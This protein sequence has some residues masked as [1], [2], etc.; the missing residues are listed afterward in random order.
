[1]TY[2]SNTSLQ[3]MFRDRLATNPDGKALAFFNPDGTYT[4][5]TFREFHE[6]G[7][8]CGSILSEMGMSRGDVCV[9]MLP[10]E[11]IS[12]NVLF[13]SLL[14]GALPLMVAPPVVRGLHSNLKD[15][16]EHVVNTTSA[17][18][19]VL[20][21]DERALGE[22]LQKSHPEIDVLYTSAFEQ[23][24]DA[25]SAPLVYPGPA[26][27]AA[28]Q[29][30]S[31][32]TGF[33]RVCVWDQNAVLQALDGMELA[34]KLGEED[35]CVNWTPPVP[36][37]GTYQQFHALHGKGDTAGNAGDHQF[38][39]KTSDVVAGIVSKRCNGDLVTKFRLY[40]YSA[41]SE[42]PPSQGHRPQQGQGVLERCRTHTP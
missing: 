39:E 13:G 37:Y 31:G 41:E 32:T 24:G 4:W 8:R 25:D 15:V 1:M 23:G 7:C 12:A 14:I 36:R 27:L 26:D 21:D 5:R 42:G 3:T 18:M 34:M 19:V 9:F 40:L 6:T 11:E 20:E 10:S 33:P 16:L 38:P 30:T 17:R 29:L 35:V 2:D 22:A 28:L